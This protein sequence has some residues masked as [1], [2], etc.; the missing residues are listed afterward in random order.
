[1]RILIII[2]LTIHGNWASTKHVDQTWMNNNG[3]S[4]QSYRSAKPVDYFK[5]PAN[6]QQVSRDYY[7]GWLAQDVSPYAV[8]TLSTTLSVHDECPMEEY[9]NMIVS[10]SSSCALASP[11]GYKTYDTR[12]PT[13]PG[14]YTGR[15]ITWPE[16]R[17]G[18]AGSN[19][20]YSMYSIKMNAGL[21][22]RD[23]FNCSTAYEHLKYHDD[24]S[25]YINP[26]GE[27]QTVTDGDYCFFHYLPAVNRSD[28]SVSGPHYWRV[29]EE[30]EDGKK[31]IKRGMAPFMPLDNDTRSK[32]M[33]N[34][35]DVQFLYGRYFV[36]MPQGQI[37]LPHNGLN[38]LYNRYSTSRPYHQVRVD[39]KVTKSSGL[40][41]IIAAVVVGVLTFGVGLAV[42]GA[43]TAVVVATA[44]S[45]AVITAVLLY[46]PGSTYTYAP[47]G[48]GKK[49]EPWGNQGTAGW[50]PYI[51]LQ[52]EVNPKKFPP[53]LSSFDTDFEKRVLTEAKS[54]TMTAKDDDG[55]N[56]TV[57]LNGDTTALSSTLPN[58]SEVQAFLS[59]ERLFQF[60]AK[61][62][63]DMDASGGTPLTVGPDGVVIPVTDPSVAEAWAR[64]Q[65][66]YN[67]LKDLWESES[68]S[69]SSGA[70][71]TL[72]NAKKT[73][74][75]AA[76]TAGGR[77]FP[78]S[79][80]YKKL[81][82]ILS[83]HKTRIEELEAAATGDDRPS[84]CPYS[85]WVQ[86]LPFLS[87]T[88]EGRTLIQRSVEI[89]NA[90]KIT[91]EIYSRLWFETSSPAESTR[92]NGKLIP[93][94]T[95]ICRPFLTPPD[96]VG[97]D[98][99]L[100]NGD[101][102]N[103]GFSP[104]LSEYMSMEVEPAIAGPFGYYTTQTG[105]GETTLGFLGLV[106]DF[107]HRT[108]P[109]DPYSQHLKSA[110]RCSEK[111]STT[112]GYA[113]CLAGLVVSAASDPGEILQDLDQRY[114]LE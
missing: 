54:G 36:P 100:E 70:L 29:Q 87:S 37:I 114:S 103:P 50:P 93:L 52:P 7:D 76:I 12:T 11:E 72:L 8:G 47:E 95:S 112:V 107:L 62:D 99:C 89:E 20:L 9:F 110:Y 65:P 102:T 77:S 67:D 61:S 35:Y 43:V 13:A 32:I 53:M 17:E 69:D 101:S 1:M 94:V 73:D 40:L 64:Y 58:A 14:I 104:I 63:Y 49:T 80:I 25:E 66:L 90:Q 34:E 6:A 108:S 59:P 46:E 86:I 2:L 39:K 109:R 21:I 60:W 22:Y 97:F 51:C 56:V 19:D 81:S 41:W 26:T 96:T 28:G 84:G 74:T 106:Q 48:G 18:A 24:E 79:S 113:A 31:Y 3:A 105:E 85:T 4:T 55:N 16:V 78:C 30:D 5:I 15:A 91:D 88:N 111:T 57:P 71:A 23:R 68:I 75:S 83:T 98:N 27:L 45:A 42:A 33:S 92:L 82:T 10:G 38:L 44:I